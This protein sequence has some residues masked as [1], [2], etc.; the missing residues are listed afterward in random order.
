MHYEGCVDKSAETKCIVPTIETNPLRDTLQEDGTLG[1]TDEKFEPVS[2]EVIA[3]F[4]LKNK[5]PEK[6]EETEELEIEGDV[7]TDQED[8]EHEEAEHRIGFDVVAASGE[9]QYGTISLLRRAN[10]NL[11]FGWTTASF[12]DWLLLW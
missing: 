10:L 3:H 5:E 1:E 8:N 2:G 4:T 12:V 9:A 11:S 6:C 7:I